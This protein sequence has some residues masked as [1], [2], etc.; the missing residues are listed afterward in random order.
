MF[1][2]NSTIVALGIAGAFGGATTGTYGQERDDLS[3]AGME[4]VYYD[5][6]DE[7]GRLSGGLIY[8]PLPDLSGI[9]TAAGS[10]VTTILDNGPPA[11][12]V[13][14]VFVGD[15]YLESELGSY[16]VHA[17]N[18]LNELLSQEPFLTY[19]TYFN[20]HRV[21]VISN[22]S[23]VDNDPVPDINR[24]TALDMGFWCSGIERLLC[25]NVSKAYQHA[26]N[27]ADIDQVFAVANSTKYGGAGYSSSDL[28]TYSGGNGLATEV[29]IHEL[30]HSLGN[31]ADEYDY[32]DGATYEGPELP[33]R[34]VSILDADAMDAAGTKWALWLGDP[35]IG[36]DGLVDTYEGARYYEFGIY[37]P[38]IN[39]KMR[40]LNRPFNLPSA[41]AIIIEVYKLLDPIDDATPTGPPLDGTEIVFVDPLEPGG[42]AL[43]V[44]WFLDGFP[45]P[46]ATSATLDLA[47]LDLAPGSYQLSVTVSDP[48]EL[49]RDESARSQWMS[50]S[51]VWEVHVPLP[52]DLNGDGA[53]GIGDLFLLLAAWGPCADCDNC[54]ADLDDDCTVGVGDLLILF[55]NWG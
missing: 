20:A 54:P 52:G 50:Q 13:D 23:G 22:E 26:N 43:D 8:L 30:G 48:T 55:A 21:D 36:F 35:G 45:L 49:V 47:A 37:R 38:S 24:D 34:N 25:V 29:A 2:S 39:S 16:A 33:Q 53:V 27:A 12:R 14:L 31:L 42:H 3:R 15:G 19:S 18:G 10:A 40:S 41:E 5:A 7:Q 28:A 32:N 46:V 51:L 11:N 9:P 1:S 44:Q 4:R 6:P 17:V